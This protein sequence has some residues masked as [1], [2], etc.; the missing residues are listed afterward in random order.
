LKEKMVFLQKTLAEAPFRRVWR[1]ALDTLQDLLFNE[2]LLKQDFTTLGSLRFAADVAAIH[3]VVDS[4]LTRGNPMIMPKLKESAA[5]LSLPTHAEEDRH[6]LSEV[7]QEMYASSLQATDC[8]ENLGI[9]YL[10]NGEGRLILARRV[11]AS[12]E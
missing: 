5:L 2:V 1:E 12:N 7:V 9:V 10:T 4:V 3:S 6:P 11:E 8:L